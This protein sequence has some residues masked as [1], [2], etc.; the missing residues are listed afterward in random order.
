MKWKQSDHW[1]SSNY[2][3]TGR[4][5]AAA[6]SH[7]SFLC[8]SWPWDKVICNQGEPLHCC[9][10]LSSVPT[11]SKLSSP[12]HLFPVTTNRQ[13]VRKLPELCKKLHLTGDLNLHFHGPVPCTAV[14]SRYLCVAPDLSRLCHCSLHQTCHS[15]VASE[16]R[17]ACP[18][19]SWG[20]S[21]EQQWSTLP[22][23][24]RGRAHTGCC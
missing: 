4:C 22:L 14:F 24:P 18:E 16:G 6:S 11:Q 19:C 21:A 10:P 15:F 23:S 9:P 20:S 7:T 17:S 12:N 8:W 3:Q 13:K 5:I 1:F 2:Y